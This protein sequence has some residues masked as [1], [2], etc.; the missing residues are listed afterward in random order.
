MKH[1]AKKSNEA[2]KMY[3]VCEA[4]GFPVKVSFGENGSVRIKPCSE[5]IDKA[6]EKGREVKA[7]VNGAK[8]LRK[9]R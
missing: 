8:Y 1:K 9:R 2:V 7:E 4:C 6:F 3:F 5:C